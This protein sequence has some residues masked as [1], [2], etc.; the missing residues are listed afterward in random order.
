MTSEPFRLEVELDRTASAPMHAQIA[1]PLRELIRTGALPPG[2][3][4]ED[5]VSMAKRL[6]VSRP[7]VRMALSSLVN[8][9]LIVR[10]RGAGTRVAPRQVHRPM[11]LT[12]LHDDLRGEGRTPGTKVLEWTEGPAEPEVAEAL[13]VDVGAPVVRIRRLRL[14]DEVPLAILV[15]HLRADLAPTAA[16]LRRAGLYELLRE[17]GVEITLGT[18]EIGARLATA[19]EA[20][21]LDEEPGAALLTM[22]RSAFDDD[23]TVVEYG[24][25][26]HRA[27]MYTYT[28]TLHG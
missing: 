10:R 28:Q 14:I 23:L 1:N 26:V 5:E 18:Q 15:N 24:R 19:E 9:G 25:H 27:S 8:M 11:A 3:R 16:Q 22:R 6:E 4:L 2:T 20:K 17:R 13:H 7:T 21:L 12:S